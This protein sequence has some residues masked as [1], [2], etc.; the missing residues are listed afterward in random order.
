MTEYPEYNPLDEKEL[1]P[2]EKEKELT[3]TESYYN[4]YESVFIESLEERKKELELLRYSLETYGNGWS[5][6]LTKIIEKL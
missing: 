6:L 1:L 2:I 3:L 4:G 5:V